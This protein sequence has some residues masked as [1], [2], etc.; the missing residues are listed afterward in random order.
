MTPPQKDFTDYIPPNLITQL[1]FNKDNRNQILAT[2]LKT[3]LKAKH[4]YT[5]QVK[6]FFIFII[7]RHTVKYMITLCIPNLL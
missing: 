2:T 6:N 1:H 3:E 5:I 4:Y 7:H